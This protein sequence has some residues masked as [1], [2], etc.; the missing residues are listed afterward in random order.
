MIFLLLILL[1]GCLPKIKPAKVQPTLKYL[2]ITSKKGMNNDSVLTID[3]VQIFEEYVW[4]EI[5]GLSAADYFQKKK[6]ILGKN[7][8]IWSI[9][10]T[11]DFW[12]STLVL[13]GYQKECIGTL[14]FTTYPR[15]NKIRLKPESDC[16]LIHC[17]PDQLLKAESFKSKI[18][19]ATPVRHL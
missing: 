6:M 14:L 8:R 5:A 11:D 12:S 3:V 4:N 1:G 10:V 2:I 19:Q 16:T 17:G 7:V 13:E 9:D 15:T 18:S